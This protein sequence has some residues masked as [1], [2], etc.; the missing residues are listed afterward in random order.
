MA[1]EKLNEEKKHNYFH[2]FLLLIVAVGG[3]SYLYHL[4]EEGIFEEL[5]NSMNPIEV[6]KHVES[7]S[8]HS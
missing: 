1:G 6:Q 8:R 2:Y 4:I 3:V 5:F 7:L